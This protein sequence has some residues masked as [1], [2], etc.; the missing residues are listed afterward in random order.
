MYAVLQDLILLSGGNAVILDI[1]K[2]VLS[3]GNAVILDIGKVLFLAIVLLIHV[4]II[5]LTV[6]VA[7]WKGQLLY[8]KVSVLGI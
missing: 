8:P 7:H 1:G 5:A 3:G 2:V 4:P 6:L